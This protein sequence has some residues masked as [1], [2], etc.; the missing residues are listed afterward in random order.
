MKDEIVDITAGFDDS[1]IDEDL[2]L[3]DNKKRR[4]ARGLTFKILRDSRDLSQAEM[5]KLLKVSRVTYG[6]FERGKSDVT[7][8]KM[9]SWLTILGEGSLSISL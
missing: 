8:K 6:N 2:K 4:I 9:D 1:T 5:S 7:M 3:L